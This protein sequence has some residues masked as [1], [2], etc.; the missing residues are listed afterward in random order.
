MGD[1]SNSCEINRLSRLGVRDDPNLEVTPAR[2]TVHDALESP[3]SMSRNNQSSIEFVISHDAACRASIHHRPHKLDGFHLFG[4]AIDQVA[5]KNRRAR[6]VPINAQRSG[7]AEILE[8][9]DELVALT[10]HV[11]DD[12]ESVAHLL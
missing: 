3:Y 9:C 4:A 7:I 8:Q 12:I 11:A 6:R 2:M 1:T 10:V 5:N